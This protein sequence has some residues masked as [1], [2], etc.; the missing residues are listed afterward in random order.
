MVETPVKTSRQQ[1][2]S[3]GAPNENLSDMIMPIIRTTIAR[4]IIIGI[5]IG[6]NLLSFWGPILR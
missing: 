4:V 3:G 6:E 5:V 2:T 1:A